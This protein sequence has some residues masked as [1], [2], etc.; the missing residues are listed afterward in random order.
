MAGKIAKEKEEEDEDKEEDMEEEKDYYDADAY[1]N[2]AEAEM[3]VV[4]SSDA[5]KLMPRRIASTSAVSTASDDRNGI[6][7]GRSEPSL[8]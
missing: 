4:T 2:N 7:I 1:N 5:E 8:S 6:R 3:M